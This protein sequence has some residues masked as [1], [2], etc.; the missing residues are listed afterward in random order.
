MPNII[1]E[2]GV[3]MAKKKKEQGESSVN[4]NEDSKQD[5]LILELLEELP[6]IRTENYIAVQIKQ[7]K[8]RELV[9]IDDERMVGY[10]L[11]EMKDRYKIWAKPTVIKNCIAYKK[12][13]GYSLEV[14]ELK[15]RIAYYDDSIIY[16][17]ADGN[18]V[19]VDKGGWRIK[20]NDYIFFKSYNGDAVCDGVQALLDAPLAVFKAEVEYFSPRGWKPPQRRSLGDTD[21]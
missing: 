3:I 9:P 6:L 16:D 13:D 20:E 10:L 2:K 1:K 11:H 12:Y 19:V 7:D 18:C 4:E 14:T 15:P 5:K 8:K 21:A 17:L